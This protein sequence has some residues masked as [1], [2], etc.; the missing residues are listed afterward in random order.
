MLNLAVTDNRDLL[1]HHL[2]S[3]KKLA[4]SATGEVDTQIS[5]LLDDGE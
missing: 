1:L 2:S 3:V 4:A 5:G